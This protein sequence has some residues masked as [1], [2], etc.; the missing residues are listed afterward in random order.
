MRWRDACMALLIVTGYACWAAWSIAW[1][2]SADR[3]A[4]AY[5]RE[6]AAAVAAAEV[7]AAWCRR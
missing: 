4:K 2:L 1:G 5:G 7:A 3:D 6:H